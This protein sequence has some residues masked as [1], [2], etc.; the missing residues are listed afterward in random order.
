[1]TIINCCELIK[2]DFYRLHK[3]GLKKYRILFHFSFIITFWY[4]ICNL[5]STRE[6]LFAKLLLL[7]SY[8]IY[9][10]VQLVT[11][12]Q[13]PRYTK[14]GK[15]LCFMH[16]SCIVIAG[17]TIIGDNCSI[18]Q[19]VTLGRSFSGINSGCPNIGNN[20][21]IFPGA[22]IIGNIKIGD[23][24]IIAANAVVIKDVPSGAV[25]AGIPAKIIKNDSISCIDE[26]WRHYFYN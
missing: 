20:V 21:I 6:S 5:L 8:V 22:K 3:K 26:E 16:H 12:I 11:G 18:H 14:V 24:A 19:G 9:S 17:G 25:V 1:M 4:R 13:I 15:G 23:N 2:S 10:I 7:V